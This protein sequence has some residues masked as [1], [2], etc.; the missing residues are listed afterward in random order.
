MN[1]IARL[2]GA[3]SLVTILR[4]ALAA[5]GGILVENG[6]F[7]PGHWQTISGAILTILPLVLGVKATITPK[8]V[9]DNG[10]TVPMKKMPPTTA[11]IAN[12]Q[13]KTVAGARP[14]LLE[15][16]RSIFGRS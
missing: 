10:D 1:L 5:L 11:A 9:A 12:A 7:D 16:L 8:V 4:Y 15:R 6:N 3:P 2:F 13:A 14:N